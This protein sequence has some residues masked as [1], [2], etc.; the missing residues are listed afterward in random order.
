MV[1]ALLSG[2]FLIKR[3]EIFNFIISLRRHTNFFTL[4]LTSQYFSM[5]LGDISRHTES[6]VNIRCN[7]VVF[8]PRRM[9]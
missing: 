4:L 8:V 9:E 3:N 6:N 2:Y 1:A 5:Y 7:S